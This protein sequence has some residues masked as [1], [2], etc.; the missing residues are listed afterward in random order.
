MLTLG[1]ETSC[2]ETAAS[3]VED[4]KKI[5]SNVVS[6]SVYLHRKFGGVVPEIASRCHVEFMGY[7]LKKALR[8]ASVKYRDIDLIA[9]TQGP[10]LVGALMVG[11]SFAK[12]LS[13]ALDVPLV[14]VNHLQAHIYA[15]MMG[16]RL[17]FP[18]IGVVLSGGHTNIFLVEDFIRFK[19]L[20]KTKDDAI[21]EAFDKVAKIL[22][23]GYPGGPVIERLAK[24]GRPKSIVFPQTTLGDSLD[25][26]FSGL[27]TAVLYYTKEKPTVRVSDV[28]AS[29]QETIVETIIAR[30]LLA[31]QKNKL[32][33]LVIGGG[34]SV[35]G[36]LRD[37]LKGRA[38]ERGIEVFFPEA[39]LCLDN[40]AM[41]AGLGYQLHKRG[42]IS[43]LNLAAAANLEI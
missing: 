22:K 9:V 12:A 42:V 32:N 31:C 11:I 15:T 21:G 17:R 35:N 41:I 1:I 19:L 6:S 5:L 34:V 20:G 4:G 40:A 7:V 18:F 39:T 30:V 2:D 38:A 29:F 43:G 16:F 14:G 8:E 37:K 10:R 3:V 27:K 24:K 28:C 23:L 33:Q 36:R 25:F 26:S 13:F